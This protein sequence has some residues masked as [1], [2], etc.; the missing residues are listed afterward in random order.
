VAQ[1]TGAN[2]FSGLRGCGEKRA[3]NRRTAGRALD[4]VDEKIKTTPKG[5]TRAQRSS[6][7]VRGRGGG[8]SS[9]DRRANGLPQVGGGGEVNITTW[10][11][12]KMKREDMRLGEKKGDPP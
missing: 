5:H 7:D 12:A 11:G 10:A 1:V 2:I 4:Q 3:K 6:L 8:G 9:S